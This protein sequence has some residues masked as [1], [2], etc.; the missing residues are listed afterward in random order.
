MRCAAAL[1]LDAFKLSFKPWPGT[2]FISGISSSS[3]SPSMSKPCA[4]NLWILSLA[5][6]A[7]SFARF[8]RRTNSAL[9]AS[10]LSAN[11]NGFGAGF[12]S[13]GASSG[14]SGGF[15]LPTAASACVAASSEAFFPCAL[16]CI[17]A[18]PAMSVMSSSTVACR[19]SGNVCVVIRFKRNFFPSGIIPRSRS[20]LGSSVPI[21]PPSSLRS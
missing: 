8:R 18:S 17:Q 5:R 10:A 14:A 4:C 2:G 20:F 9:S 7:R 19:P 3:N 15:A 1:I 12:F 21:P 11:V 13:G 16:T 6:R